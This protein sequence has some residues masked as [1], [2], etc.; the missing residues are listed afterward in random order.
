[1]RPARRRRV[2]DRHPR[3]FRP[4]AAP[5]ASPSAV[6]DALSQP[7][8][9]DHHKLFIGASVGSAV[10]PRR[11]RDRRDADAQRR[12]RALPREGRRRRRS[13][14]AYEP[15]LHANAEERR[16]LEFSLRHAIGNK[17]LRLN[18]QPVVD[19][20][21]RGAGQLRGAA[22][23][24]QRGARHGQPRQVHP[25]RR[26]HP[27]DRPDRRTGCCTRRAARRCA[28]RATSR[29]RST[30]RASSCSNRAL[31]ATSS[32]RWAT[33]ACPRTGSRSRSPNRSSCAMH[34]P[35]GRRLRRSWR[36]AA[37]SRSTTSAPAIP[38]SATC[39]R[40]AS[41][42]SRSTAASSRARRK[43][44]RES[45]AIIRAVVAMAQSL[46][47]T[48]TA[49]GVETIEEVEMIRELGCDKIQGYYFGRPMEAA[50]A[51]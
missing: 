15:S 10:C 33:A 41:R 45:L 36:S 44:S 31:P 42:R 38:R 32:G 8:D 6:I 46:E 51:L 17:E 49:E 47:M 34:A 25:A 3:R 4:R 35:R 12:P 1:M 26:G 22:A 28:G 37:R 14:A 21:Q 27:P 19:A 24:A 9:V 7:Y 30:S 29:W 48:T 18:F 39:A 43:G 2:R 20:Q 40:C 16:K 13:I 23:L 5:S 50:D 11:R